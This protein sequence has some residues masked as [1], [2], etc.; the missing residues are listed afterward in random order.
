MSG[1]TRAVNTSRA[2]PQLLVE[3]EGTP[4]Q[5]FFYYTDAGGAEKRKLRAEPA[6]GAPT[7]APVETAGTP[8]DDD[9]VFCS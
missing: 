6:K 7:L 4:D 5:L 8:V 2:Q 3:Q 9:H 1:R